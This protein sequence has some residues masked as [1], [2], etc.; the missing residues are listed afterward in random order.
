MGCFLVQLTAA[1]QET[2]AACPCG[3]A[4][5]TT[6]ETFAD[7]LICRA[8][9]SSASRNFRGVPLHA[10]RQKEQLNPL[11]LMCFVN[12]TSSRQ[13]HI[14]NLRS[15][16]CGAESSTAPTASHLLVHIACGMNPAL[17]RH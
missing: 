2:C 7:G 15:V 17:T 1:H 3:A 4:A 9:D 14:R 6:A 8:A 12:Y 5:T 10:T 11:E 13:E 16:P